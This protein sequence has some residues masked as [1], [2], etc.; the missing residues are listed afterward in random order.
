VSSKNLWDRLTSAEEG[1][2]AYSKILLKKEEVAGLV[3]IGEGAAGQG[4]S[5]RALPLPL[6]AFCVLLRFLCSKGQGFTITSTSYADANCPSLAMA[7]SL[8]APGELIVTF[9]SSVAGFP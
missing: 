8:Y 3:N 4:K 1:S 6:C 2:F 7:R 9:V 5:S